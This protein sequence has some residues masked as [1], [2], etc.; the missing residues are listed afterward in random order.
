MPKSIFSRS[1]K[2][3]LNL[4]NLT[5]FV[6]H[7]LESTP[8]TLPLN[9][10]YRQS[11]CVEILREG[12]SESQVRAESLHCLEFDL[13]ESLP[14]L[15]DLEQG[16]I[17]GVDLD[18]TIMTEDE[19]AA[20]DIRM[21]DQ[22]MVESTLF[23]YINGECHGKKV[24]SQDL[25]YQIQGKKLIK[26]IQGRLLDYKNDVGKAVYSKCVELAESCRCYQKYC[27]HAKM[28]D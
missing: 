28:R 1:E 9:N 26:S 2:S 16:V 10:D 18:K 23:M 12:L 25:R 3:Q 20:C 4:S 27:G 5:G 13:R 15:S 11:N 6:S 22:D 24:L 7:H 14:L 8:I 17:F 19:L 21:V